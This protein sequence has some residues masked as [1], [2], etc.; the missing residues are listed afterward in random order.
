[1][2]TATVRHTCTDFDS[3]RAARVKSLFNVESGANFNLDAQL[4]AD[5]PAWQI[6]VIVGPSGSGKTSLGRA[7]WGPGHLHAPEWPA[8]APIVDAIAPGGGFD[9]V[10]AALGSVGLGDVPAWLR[11]FHVLSQGE[12]F[13][14]NL[15]R[16]IAERPA[17]V[18]VDEFTSVVDRQIARVGAAAFAKAWRRGPGQAVLLT[19]HRDVLDWICPDWVFDTETCEYTSGR[20]W[21][22][23]PVTLEIRQ[24][25]WTPWKLF[26]RHHYLKLP[27][28]PCARC[29]VGLV[30]GQPVCHVAVAPRLEIGMVRACRLV[31]LPEWQGAGVGLHFLNEIARREAHGLNPWRRQCP[32]LFHTSHPNLAAALRRSPVWVQCSA[33]LHGGNKAKSAASMFKSRS[34]KA[35]HLSKDIG[36]GGHL[37]AVQGFKY[38]ER[39]PPPPTPP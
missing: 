22:R 3:Y 24:T 17:R 20:L 2:I 23:P 5:D 27:P 33:V 14:A 11:P 31:V 34:G 6:G 18:V 16:L 21:R 25:N 10:T 28:M 1:M 29:F 26:E 30:E 19:C 39:P 12:Q 8:A 15:A 7:M 38:I 36:Y 37:R 32:T 13:R 9:D 35:T 4:P